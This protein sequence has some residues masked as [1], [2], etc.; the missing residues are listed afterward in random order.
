MLHAAGDEKLQAFDELLQ[1]RHGKRHAMPFRF[2]KK[3]LAAWLVDADGWRK[4]IAS[5]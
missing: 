4:A 1:Y 2:Q 3:A 5:W